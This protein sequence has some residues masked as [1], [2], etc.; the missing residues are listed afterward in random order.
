MRNRSLSCVELFIGAGG[1]ALGISQA[2]FECRAAVEIDQHACDTIRANQKAGVKHVADWPL[3]QAD[4]RTVEFARFGTDVDLVSGGVPCQPFSLGGKHRGNKDDR[5]LFPE[6]VRVVRELKPRAFLFENVKG[7]VRREFESYLEYITLQ[8]EFP[9]FP[10]QA[11]EDWQSHRARLLMCR[12]G[13]SGE[14]DVSLKVLNAANYGVPQKRDRVFIVGI[15]RDLDTRFEYPQP[16]HSQERL[17]YEQ[18]V[19]RGYWRK[20][21]LPQERAIDQPPRVQAQARRIQESLFPPAGEAWRTVRD[22]IG[23]LPRLAPGE[24]HDSIPNHFAN[25]GAR[26]YPGHTGSPWD[27]PSKTLKAGVHGVPGGEN[28]LRDVD[29]SVRYFTVR[30]AADIQTFPREFLFAGSWSECMRQV[31]NAVPVALAEAVARQVAV[32]LAQ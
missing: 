26:S 14:Y 31:G 18:Y 17:L 8:L 28:T 16:T 3:I 25:P 23:D 32:C 1:L 29:G 22:A 24:T 27:A 4:V 30:E 7:L 10:A 19:S 6:A 20:H 15:R 13:T 11:A 9:D 21:G 12:R 5:D 2:G